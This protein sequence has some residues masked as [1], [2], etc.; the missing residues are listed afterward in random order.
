MS[1][2]T[3]YAPSA[4]RAIEAPEVSVI[5]ASYNY[6]RFIAVAIESVLAQSISNWELIIVD[7]GSVDSSTDVIRSYLGRDA[8]IRFFQHPGN[9]NLGLPATLRL[10]L[11]QVRGSHVAFLES[12]D[13]WRPDCLEKR[14]VCLRSSGADAVFNHIEIMERDDAGKSGDSILVEMTRRRFGKYPAAFQLLEQLV[15][16]NSIP[17]FSC[18]MLKVEMLAQADLRAPVP[19]W[20]D[21]WLWLEAA[22]K[23][24]FSY[25]DEPCTLWR[26]HALSY[27]HKRKTG[28]YSNDSRK[29]WAAMREAIPKWRAQLPLRLRLLLRLPFHVYL[30]L[31]FLHMTVTSGPKGMAR[32]LC[33]KFGRV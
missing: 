11:E 28:D 2:D 33:S 13:A 3:L 16:S 22:S 9:V 25:L 5:M 8:R 21:W 30:A 14:L 6:E 12:D 24:C 4:A 20:L 26:R 18:I 31:R 19:R 23:G 29:M 10:G 7:D 32:R 17:T 27:N 15:F 1:I